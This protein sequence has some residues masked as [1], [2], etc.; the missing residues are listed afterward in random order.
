MRA[1]YNLT[2]RELP[3]LL[4][5]LLNSRNAVCAELLEAQ[6]DRTNGYEGRNARDALVNMKWVIADHR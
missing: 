2:A 3:V 4:S 5:R 1:D 6:T